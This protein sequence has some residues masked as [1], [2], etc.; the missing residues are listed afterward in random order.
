MFPNREEMLSSHWMLGCAPS[1]GIYHCPREKSDVI[2]ML[3]RAVTVHGIRAI[4][5]APWYGCG[6]SEMHLGEAVAQLPE[7][8]RK[9]LKIYTKAGRVTLAKSL[10][11][12]T[13]ALAVAAANLSVT[14]E[15]LSA[16]MRSALQRDTCYAAGEDTDSSVCVEV[17]TADGIQASWAASASRLGPAA[18]ACVVSVRL[19]D[20][21]TEALVSEAVLRGGMEALADVFPGALPS[22]GLND[23]G[24]ALRY[25]LA[26][27]SF[28]RCRVTPSHVTKD[29]TNDDHSVC[30]CVAVASS[31]SCGEQNQ[32]QKHQKQQHEGHFL[33]S[34]MIAGCWNLFDFS[35]LELLMECDRRGVDVHLAGVFAG[36]YVWGGPYYRYQIPATDELAQDLHFRRE[37]WKELA[38]EYGVSLPVVALQLAMLPRCVRYVAVGC[39]LQAELDMCVQLVDAFLSTAAFMELLKKAHERNLLPSHVF[40]ALVPSLL[41][42]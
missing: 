1:A 12:D 5:T 4:D 39:A 10:V 35:A 19:H 32:Q 41:A 26:A 22:L 15:D 16:R 24:V 20:A 9:N 38:S 31:S 21:D 29:T 34:V 28:R 40:E 23:A 14:V 33:D 2:A 6:R 27:A 36:G 7:S 42:C 11:N 17:C 30:N 13:S 37:Q 8:A 25:V 3:T 18:A